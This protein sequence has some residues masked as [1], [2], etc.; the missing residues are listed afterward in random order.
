MGLVLACVAWSGFVAPAEMRGADSPARPA[1][2]PAA[3]DR[4]AE[5]DFKAA[6]FHEQGGL[7]LS[8]A[9]ALREA[10]RLHLRAAQAGYLPAMIG[11][12]RVANASLQQGGLDAS[13]RTALERGIVQ[14]VG[15]AADLGHAESLRVRA[16]WR[17]QGQAGLARDVRRAL[18]ELEQAAAS[19]DWP[20]MRLL[21]DAARS[22]AGGAVDLDAAETWLERAKGAG[23]PEAGRLLRQLS[24][25]RQGDPQVL[26]ETVVADVPRELFRALKSVHNRHPSFPWGLEQVERLRA[27]ILGD[28]E[29]DAD[30]RRLVA[31]LTQPVFHLRLVAR[32]SPT[33]EPDDLVL[34]GSLTAAARAELARFAPLQGRAQRALWLETSDRGWAKAVAFARQGEEQRDEVIG[35]LVENL[36]AAGG[37]STLENGFKPVRDRIQG[38]HNIISRLPG[39]D[40]GFAR[41]DLL[42]AAA[43]AAHDGGAQG[44]PLFAFNW[45][46]RTP[47]EVVAYNLPPAWI[48]LLQ[49]LVRTKPFPWGEP[50]AAR[51][52][53]E[54]AKVGPLDAQQQAVVKGWLQ[55]RFRMHLVGARKPGETAVQIDLDGAFAPGATAPLARLLP[56]P[57]GKG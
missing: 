17:L 55:P 38:Y 37:A 34:A 47:D 10:E 36:R 16:G 57:A 7:G 11:Y 49:E 4:S 42:R 8:P 19:G 5:E 50:E 23:D 48:A 32:K 56:A 6:L 20:S 54:L 14:W 27:G 33:F 53:D 25:E 29:F 41:A 35:I 24:R 18:A 28:D 15:R 40:G 13:E 1:A 45:I 46:K 2:A 52:A 30:E 44:W 9:D 39:A 22:G 51:L 21:A 26:P 3:A 31:A 12:V 43:A